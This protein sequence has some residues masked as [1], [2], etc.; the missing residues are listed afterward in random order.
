MKVM[1][2]LFDSS[3]AYFMCPEISRICCGIDFWY[4]NVTDLRKSPDTESLNVTV[5]LNES[6]GAIFPEEISAVVHSHEDMISLTY[7]VSG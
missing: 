1:C 2:Y 7:S 5:T 4:F 3:Y 6:P